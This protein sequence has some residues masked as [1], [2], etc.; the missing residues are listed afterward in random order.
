MFKI[1]KLFKYF[2]SL[3]FAITLLGSM[4]YY[5]YLTFRMTIGGTLSAIVILWNDYLQGI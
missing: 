5:R 1:S 4:K 3:F 2:Y